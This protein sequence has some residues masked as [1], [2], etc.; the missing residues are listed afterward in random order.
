[1]KHSIRL[2]SLFACL[3]MLGC[4][5]PADTTSTADVADAPDAAET[6]KDV[7]FDF[8]KDAD[9]ASTLESNGVVVANFTADW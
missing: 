3:V 7:S 5:E 6:A 8:V 4:G 1:M 9:F 2:A